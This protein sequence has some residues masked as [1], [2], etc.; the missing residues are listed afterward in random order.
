MRHWEGSSFIFIL[1]CVGVLILPLQWIGA[2]IFAAAIHELCHVA[3]MK[4]FG[5]HIYGIHVNM[6]KIEMEI[7][8]TTPWKELIC[9]A[10]GPLGSIMLIQLARYAP[11]VGICAAIQAAYNLMPILP[12]D[13]G[14]IVFN[15]C[16]LLFGE[17]VAERVMIINA[18]LIG[19]LVIFLAVISL[20]FVFSFGSGIFF[21]MLLTRIGHQLK[22]SLQR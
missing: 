8:K 6:S 14:R 18:C 12:L 1:L 5:I 13:G 22:N 15:F 19:L 2:A 10:A 7:E 11:R 3:A 9:A 20:R 4:A 21:I 16:K 17:H